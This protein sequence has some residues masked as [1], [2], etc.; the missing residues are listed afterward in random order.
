MVQYHVR[1][2][3]RQQEPRPIGPP[4]VKVKEFL[5]IVPLTERICVHFE[6]IEIYLD[7]RGRYFPNSP[8]RLNGAIFLIISHVEMSG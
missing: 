3:I 5:T 6:E 8:R 2:V 1:S 4:P 7:R